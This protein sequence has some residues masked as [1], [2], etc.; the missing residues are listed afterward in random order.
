M[1]VAVQLIQANTDTH[2]WSE[3]YDRELEDIFAVQDDI[4]QSVVTELRRSLLGQ[5]SDSLASVKVKGEVMT[6][7]KGRSENAEAH[8]LDL[9]PAL[10]RIASLERTR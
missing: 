5:E 1:R 3:T 10:L 6:A 4:A 7:T 9:E 2:L 8:P